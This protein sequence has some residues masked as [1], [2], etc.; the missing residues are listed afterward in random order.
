M[1]L[2]KFERVEG[3]VQKMDSPGG[4]WFHIFVKPMLGAHF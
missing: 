3:G 4:Y 1:N 2:Y